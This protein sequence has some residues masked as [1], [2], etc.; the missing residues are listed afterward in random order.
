MFASRGLHLATALA[1]AAAVLLLMVGAARSAEPEFPA[2]TGR[3]VDAAG[4]LSPAVHDQLGRM[5]AG[6]EQSTG[7]QLVVV[8]LKSLQGFT[9]EEFGY[10]LGRHWGIGQSGQNNGALLIAAPNERKVRI[11]VGYGLEGRLTDAASRTIIENVILPRF[12]QGDF[13]GG[14]LDGATAILRV[15][16]GGQAST[17]T[18]APMEV[19]AIDYIVVLIPFG[20]LLFFGLL[21]FVVVSTTLRQHRARFS[22]ESWGGSGASSGSSYSSSSGSSDS[23]SSSGGGGSFGGG[24][25]SGSW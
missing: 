4:I 3:V 12:R 6:H 2:L 9:V 23:D 1:V 13:S 15:L 14:T 25:A 7:Q 18:A 17:G 21:A 24:G 19:R 16:G 11:E 22:H 10:Q 8:T 5:L 20:F